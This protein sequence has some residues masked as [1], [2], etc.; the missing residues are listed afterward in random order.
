MPKKDL[1]GDVEKSEVPNEAVQAVVE[2][3]G[4]LGERSGLNRYQS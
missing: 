1:A 3:N 4:V 2:Y